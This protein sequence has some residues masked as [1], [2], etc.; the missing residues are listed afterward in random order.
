MSQEGIINRFM[1]FQENLFESHK[2]LKKL[3]ININENILKLNQKID[4]LVDENEKLKSRLKVS[5][6]VSQQLQKSYS[7]CSKLI[8]DMKKRIHQAEQYSRRECLEIASIP[9]EVDDRCLE[10]F[11][12]EE[13]FRKFDP[14]VNTCDVSACHR[15]KSSSRVIMKFVNQKDAEAVMANKFKLRR[16]RDIYVPPD[17]VDD[18]NDG[19]VKNKDSHGSKVVIFINQ[20]LCPYYRYLYGLVKDRKNEGIIDDFKIVNG[21]IK[22]RETGSSKYISILHESDL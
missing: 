21:I 20:S 13:I 22:V 4:N 14:S 8:T 18:G 3:N 7:D 15:L 1:K 5:K 11:I 12:L 17:D 2:E 19:N 6:T 10:K 16:I 9:N